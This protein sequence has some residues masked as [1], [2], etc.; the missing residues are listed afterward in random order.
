MY[1]NFELNPFIFTKVMHI[2]NDNNES[3]TLNFKFIGPTSKATKASQWFTMNAYT[4][5]ELNLLTFTRVIALEI[6]Y[7]VK[8][9]SSTFS[10][11]FIGFTSKAVQFSI[12][13]Q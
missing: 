13:L 9:E 5:F 7:N 6:I 12:R 8:N 11:K 2:Y 10:F 1:T 4:N 3:L